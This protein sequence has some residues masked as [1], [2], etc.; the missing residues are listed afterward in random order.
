MRIVRAL[1]D[2]ALA[3]LAGGIAGGA[4]CALVLFAKAPSREVAGAVGQAIFDRLGL[5]V[6]GLSAILLACRLILQRLEPPSRSRATALAASAICVVLSG[7][8]ALWL[9]PAM[10]EIW[11]TAPHAPDGTGLVE[12]ARRPFM[13]MHGI[14]NLCYAII[15]AASAGLIVLRAGSSRTG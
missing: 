3:F 2:L 1:H 13:R 11:S 15:L 7:I 10:A 5:I 4:V 12:E 9:T 14:A 8:I 6:L